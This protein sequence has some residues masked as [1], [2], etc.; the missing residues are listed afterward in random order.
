[1]PQSGSTPRR[2]FRLAAFL[3]GGL[4]LA[5]LLRR[6]PIQH[7]STV[8]SPMSPPPLG[9]PLPPPLE[10]KR[11]R[12][13]ALRVALA[14][15]FVTIFFA[16][17]AFTAGAGDTVAKLIQQ[18][19]EPTVVAAEAASQE[20]APAVDPSA[21]PAE[22]TAPATDTTAAPVEQP[23]PT[24]DPGVAP[25]ET[26]PV[27]TTPVETATVEA[28]P[29]P[30]SAVDDAPASAPAE[31]DTTS[32]PVPATSAPANPAPVVSPAPS[33]APARETVVVKSKPSRPA[34]VRQRTLSRV[35]ETPA[36]AP[37]PEVDTPLTASTVWLNRPLLDPTPPAARLKRDFARDMWR[38][39]KEAG[40]D[41]A[42][43]LGVLR[44]EGFEGRVP[45][46]LDT[47]RSLAERLA[48]QQKEGKSE[49]EAVTS[50]LADATQADQA[51]ALAHYNRAVGVETL[52]QGLEKSKK[53]L[54]KRTLADEKIFI[55]PGGR[56]DLEA[57]R[58]DVRVLVAIRYLEDTFGSVSVTS[59]VSGHRLYARPRV[60]SKHIYGEAVDIAAVGETPIVGH[61]E[62]GGP[63]EQAVRA[64]LLLPGELEPK[65]VISLLGLGGPSFAQA[66]HAD[67]IHIG[68]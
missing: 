50:L 37:D 42:L 25:V 66:D 2:L 14:G 59:L 47:I 48:V 67:H 23:A 6:H 7:E 55:Y 53:R 4:T 29:L 46:S 12:S 24:P 33:P 43:V 61:Q 28:A 31:A 30:V 68:Y 62:P 21:A 60:I 35:L 1:M 13:P 45:A 57:K 52:I 64:L 41:W 8:Y 38:V 11:R 5:A 17:A 58:V 34:P 9:D 49:W 44:T 40:A 51:V 3:L 18:E 22:E 54:I 39:S 56:A 65:Q 36:P 15:T 19:N 63:T 27:D 32:D 20:A 26:V 10:P 16:G